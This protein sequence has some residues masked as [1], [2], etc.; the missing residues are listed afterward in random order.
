MFNLYIDDGV[1]PSGLMESVITPID[2]KDNPFDKTNYRPIS[3]VFYKFYQ[4]FLGDVYTTKYMITLII[5]YRI[6]NVASAKVSAQNSL[7]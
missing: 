3:T 7:R 5:Y 1:F 4:K 2:E 6:Y